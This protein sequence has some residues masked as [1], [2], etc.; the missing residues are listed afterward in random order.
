MRKKLLIV[1]GMIAT[2]VLAGAGCVNKPPVQIPMQ[3]TEPITTSTPRTVTI[4]VPKNEEDYRQKMI[5]FSQVG[6]INPLTTWVFVKKEL[7]LPLNVDPIKA[8]AVLAAQEIPVGGSNSE[9]SSVAVVYWKVVN[10][11]AYVL[12]R[13][14]VDG[15]AGVS[16]AIAVTHP[17]VEKTLL[18]FP[19]IQRVIFDYAPGDKRVE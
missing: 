9:S 1:T 15:W 10:K 14:D 11:T 5:E 7:P 13:M 3:P 18:Q 6:G 12:L 4:M 2:I 19:E 16:T 17:L 8:S